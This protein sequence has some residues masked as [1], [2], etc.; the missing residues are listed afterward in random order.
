MDIKTNSNE[1]LSADFG[2][3][4][5]Y[6]I[7]VRHHGGIG[8]EFE[9]LHLNGDEQDNDIDNLIAV[10]GFM[11]RTI[12]KLSFYLSRETVEYWLNEY[13]RSGK[14]LDFKKFQKDQRRDQLIKERNAL[15]AAR[16][17]KVIVKPPTLTKVEKRA[18][19]NSF[20]KENPD[21][22]RYYKR[23]NRP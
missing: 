12:N 9:I 13:F 5:D 7:Y 6:C 8:D 17:R 4:S 3:L 19:I 11:Y 14:R 10:P 23:S 16:K 15:R 21:G 20:I 2:L 22:V 1:Y 18:E